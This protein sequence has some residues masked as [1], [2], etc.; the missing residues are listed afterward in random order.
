MRRTEVL[1]GVRRRKFEEVW[2]RWQERRLSQVDQVHPVLSLYRERYGGPV[3][4][5]ATAPTAARSTI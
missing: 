5:L 4:S 2:G 1:Q 3:V